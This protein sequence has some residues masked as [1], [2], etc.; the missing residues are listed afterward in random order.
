MSGDIGPI[1]QLGY[2]VEDAAAAA[3][4]WAERVGAGPFYVLDRNPMDDCYFRGERTPVEIRL[5][6]GYWGSVQVELVQPLTTGP[7]FYREA[8]RSGA[9]KLNHCAAIVTDLDTLLQQRN[10]QDRVILRGSMQSGLKFVYLE[11]Y[12]PGGLHLEL[13]QATPSTLG[14][15]AGMEAIARSWDGRDPVRPMSAI[16]QDLAT[17]TKTSR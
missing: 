1:M 9:G 14:A 10:L 16:A 5:A 4:E 13:I 6:F 2:I 17:V 7:S 12:L 3:A 8:L 15:F 11:E